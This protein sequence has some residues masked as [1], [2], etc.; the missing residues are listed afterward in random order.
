MKQKLLPAKTLTKQTTE[1]IFQFWAWQLLAWALYRYF[2]KFPEWT[3]EFIFKPLVFVL[4]VLWYVVKKERASLTTIGITSKNFLKNL[5]MGLGISAIF[6]VEGIFV[7][8]SKHGSFTPTPMTSVASYSFGFLF[9][10]SLA[11]ACTEELLS[12]G[13]LFS[14]LYEQSKKVWYAVLLSSLMF[15]AFHIPILATTLKF[16]GSTLVLFFWTTFSLGVINSIFYLQTRSL[17]MPILVH[18]FWNLTVAYLL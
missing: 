6:V 8:I 17:V 18:L 10:L 4:P 5:F 16:Q 1:W 3:D 9:I 2:F 11:T 14:R 13:F 12:R 7:N 15:M